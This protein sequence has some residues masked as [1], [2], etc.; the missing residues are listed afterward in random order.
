[1]ATLDRPYNVVILLAALQAFGPLSIDM[2]L[3]GLPAISQSLGSDESEI[4]LTISS[5][6]AGLFIGMLFYGPLSDKFGRR[7]LLMGGISLYVLASIGCGFAR[8]ADELVLLRFLQALGGGAASVLGRAIVRDIFAAKEAARVLS[9]MHLITMIATL[10][11]PL[12]GGLVLVLLDWRWIFLVLATFAMIVL[13]SAAWKL[14][15]THKGESRNASIGAAFYAYFEV[16][17]QLASVGYILCMSLAFAGMFAYIT[18]SPFV[19]IQYF[20]VSPQTYA[21][22]FSLNIAGVI[23]FVSI[24]ARYVN[25]SG[26]HLPLFIA[27]AAASVSGIALAIG[28]ALSIGG[29]PLIVICLFGFVGVTGVL[30]ANCM[31]SLLH[32]HPE[33][34]GA[35]SSLAVATQFGLGGAASSLVS[36]MNDGTPFPMTLVVG[37]C[38]AG[39]LLAFL[40][41]VRAESLEQK[42]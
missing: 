23:L 8:S 25:T 30:G 36:T 18:A 31:A 40:V 16:I 42:N 22:L 4:Q 24:N 28:G 35:A 13:V 6:L 17:R 20:G 2:Y 29:L 11:A 3:P 19:Y 10:L 7:P 34:A 38:G 14:P 39:S 1:M 27:A 21:W 15:E 33:K 26:T 5:F 9:L 41:A 32:R 12:V 37:L